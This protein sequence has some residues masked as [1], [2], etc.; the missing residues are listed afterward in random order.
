[1]YAPLLRSGIC[2]LN[3]FL[4]L[5]CFGESRINIELIPFGRLE[6]LLSGSQLLAIK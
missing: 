3:V 5:S 2:M 6:I 4:S 1:M